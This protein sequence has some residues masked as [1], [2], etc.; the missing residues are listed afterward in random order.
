M[1]AGTHVYVYMPEQSLLVPFTPIA[2]FYRLYSLLL[3]LW[4][5]ALPFRKKPKNH[6]IHDKLSLNYLLWK[7]KFDHKEIKQA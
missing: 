5:K 7:M 2:A 3:K 1:S 6:P 4:Y